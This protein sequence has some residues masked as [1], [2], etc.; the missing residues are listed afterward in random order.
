VVGL[1]LRKVIEH[2]KTQNWTA[3]AIDFVIVVIGVF[4]GLQVQ[5]WNNSREERREEAVL[6]RR[7]YVEAHALLGAHSQE[8]SALTA[9]A[10]VLS[11]AN[12][13]LFSHVPVRTLTEEECSAILGSHVLRRPADELPILDQMIATGR[14]DLLRSPEI[15]RILRDYIVLRERGRAHYREAVN[16]LFRLHSRYPSLIAIR[17]VR[18]TSDQDQ[19]RDGLSGDGYG[20]QSEC[21]VDAMRENTAFLNEY[22]DNLSRINSLTG[23]VAQRQEELIELERLLAESPAN[24]DEQL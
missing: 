8:L 16:E 12:P 18:N 24:Q 14:F 7:L 13:V 17:L 3:V 4:V 5:D 2:V 19:G 20:W 6:L 9:R 11:G 10:G 22:A 15:Q 23:F 1:L 21:N